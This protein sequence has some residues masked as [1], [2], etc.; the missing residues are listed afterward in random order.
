MQINVLVSHIEAPRH[1]FAKVVIHSPGARYPTV[2]D[3]YFSKIR[4][5]CRESSTVTLDFLFLSSIVYVIDKVILRNIA[6]DNWTRDIELNL[7][8]SN[9]GLWATLN[10]HL[11]L[12]LSFL[13]G[14]NWRI[15]FSQLQRRLIRPLERRWGLF[16]GR[17]FHADAICLFSG[18]LDSLVGAIDWLETNQ[19]ENILLVSHYDGDISGPHADQ[20]RLFQI[21][22]TQ[23]G[24]RVMSLKV[25]VGQKPP[26]MEPSFRCRSLLFIALGIYAAQAKGEEVPLLIP[27]NGTISLNIP[28]TPSRRGSCSTRTA[29]PFFLN[30]IRQ[31]LSELAIR[32]PL[33][34]PLECK[35]KGECVEQCLD[36]VLLRRAALESVSCAKRGHKIHW[37]RSA[38]GCGFCIPCIFRRAALQ[39][40]N[41]DI[42]A[43]GRD[44]CKDEVDLDYPGEIANDFRALISLLRKNLSREDIASLLLTNGSIDIPLL[45][46]YADLIFRALN[47]VRDFLS[48]KGSAKIKRLAGL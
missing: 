26:G 11:E 43:Y 35:T 19:E 46:R 24:Q 22:K 16:I 25:R 44:I 4:E 15:N 41:L 32:N 9:L 37:L 29:H 31:I 1:E 2:L 17:S 10:R 30:T 21:L 20:D 14:D 40:A 34:N 45:P 12:A 7:P 23:Y 39:K 27:E 6:R 36:L 33:I 18:G 38:K 48:S 47:E 5:Y 3:L 42:E 28:L 8:I 13:S